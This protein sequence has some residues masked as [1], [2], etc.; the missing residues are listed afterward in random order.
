[1]KAS[2]PPPP[3]KPPGSDPDAGKT[4][5]EYVEAIW[6]RRAPIVVLVAVGALLAWFYGWRTADVYAVRTRV[7]IA[8]QRPFGMG[9]SAGGVVVSTGEAYLESQLYYPTRWALL[10][11]PTYVDALLHEHDGPEGRTFPLWD[12]LTWPATSDAAPA[13]DLEKDLG[14]PLVDSRLVER[15]PVAAAS[16]KPL[17]EAA[18]ER[19]TGIPASAFRERFAFR[20]YG[21]APTRRVDAPFRDPS[22]LRGY[23]LDRV[24]VNP[25]KGTTLV[26]IVLEGENRQVLAPLLNL[27]I[28]AF[29]REQRSEVQRRLEREL[30]YWEGLRR[31]IEGAPNDVPPIVGELEKAEKDL[32]DWTGEH[33]TNANQLT[34]WKEMLSKAVLED[35]ARIRED[36]ERIAKMRADEEAILAGRSVTAG[37]TT[38]GA[39]GARGG[40]ATDPDDAGDRARVAALRAAGEEAERVLLPGSGDET[41]FHRLPFVVADSRVADLSTRILAASPGS[42]AVVPGLKA[43]RTAAVRDLVRARVHALTNDLDL[44]IAHREQ[45]RRD[46]AA[47]KERWTLS[48]QLSV[49]QT[50]V[51]LGSTKLAEVKSQVRTVE[52]QVAAEKDV[53]PLKVIEEAR[54]PGAPVKPNRTLLLILGAG[55]GLLLGMSLAL[56]L[57]WLDDTV[58]EPKDVERH[59]GVPVVGTVVT[60]VAGDG[61]SPDR[62]AAEQPRSPVSEAFRAIRTSVEF[63]GEEGTGGRVLMVT[64]CSPREG[65]TTVALN[66]ASVLA[67]DRKR[68]LLV[69]GDLRKPRLHKVFGVDGRVGLSNVLAGKATL[70]EAI[71]ATSEENLSLLPCGAIPPNP[72]ELLGRPSAAETFAALR[73]RFDRI[74]VDTPPL[75]VVTDAAVLAREAGLVLLVVSSGHTKKRAAE[76]GASVLRS[77]GVQ[78]AGAI[79]NL[80]RKGSRWLYGGYYDRKGKYY[81]ASSGEGDGP[82]A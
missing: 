18:L 9:S 58:S 17:G 34:L 15:G 16:L 21:P 52:S 77:V 49:L 23:L 74:V 73:S 71:V 35:A 56:L 30:V 7:D 62:M 38:D 40:D 63:V 1:M 11:S 59:L 26:E 79:L 32:A 28:E 54:D 19:L 45:Q 42:F 14:P 78:P 70:D 64:S 2:T 33:A 27:L 60:V 37:K 24:K 25:E 53:K 8:K 43:E 12:W 65:K 29:S 44:R 6:K 10:G 31:T 46:E 76:H 68:T 67:Q 51:D 72:A 5:R 81:Y 4:L 48:S 36:S 80:V 55:L 13:R 3:P 61:A 69:D 82:T 66:L 57:D 75:A 39:D 20:E 50:R 47:L 22:D 41:R